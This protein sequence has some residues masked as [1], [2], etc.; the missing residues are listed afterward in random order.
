MELASRLAEY[1]KTKKIA[2]MLQERLEANQCIH[3]KPAEDTL[4][5]Y[6]D[7]PDELLK[8]DIRAVC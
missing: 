6:L 4:S 7:S 2:E 3:E 1:V 5:E 8:A